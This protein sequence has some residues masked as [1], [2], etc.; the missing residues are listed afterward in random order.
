M[1]KLKP[2]PTSTPPAAP[3]NDAS[4]QALFEEIDSEVK[5][6]QFKEF[7]KK[8]GTLLAVLLVVVLLATASVNTWQKMRA[9][10][11]MR[12]TEALLTLLER[13]TSKLTPDEAK[14]A[15]LGLHKMGE[16]ASG[17]GQRVVA[18]LGEANLTFKS[19]PE[20]ALAA[21]RAIENDHS[22]KPLYRDYAKLMAV[23]F[24][25]DQED[26]QKLID[27][28]QPLLAEGNPWRL[29]ALETAAMLYAKKGDKQKAVGL[30]QDLVESQDAP[31]SSIER[32]RALV[33]L[34]SA[35]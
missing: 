19:E 18:R 14:A 2:R 33:R 3:A 35:S 5:A 28:T 11:Q 8:H 15:V 32:A 22:I 7:L 20:T 25:M 24:R 9:Q 26:P 23:R 1:N 29:S 17:E 4:V 31:L 21:F 27:E 6:A 10:D 13:D 34:Y 12:D 30:L 16:S